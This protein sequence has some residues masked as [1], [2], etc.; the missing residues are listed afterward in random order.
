MRG[1][2]GSSGIYSYLERL[3]NAVTLLDCTFT[4]TWKKV[5]TRKTKLTAR[6]NAC[7]VDTH[8]VVKI[9]NNSKR[10]GAIISSPS[11]F[12]S[13][14]S[15]PNQ[16]SLTVISKCI[17]TLTFT[18]SSETHTLECAINTSKS[19]MRNALVSVNTTNFLDCKKFICRG[20]TRLIAPTNWGLAIASHEVKYQWKNN[21]NAA[22]FKEGHF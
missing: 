12:R 9:Y 16:C 8:I 5:K 6:K 13:K 19:I 14:T 10:I 18:C 22:S 21:F 2:Q 3:N 20:K 1:H 7:C 11:R 17:F 4:H 15:L